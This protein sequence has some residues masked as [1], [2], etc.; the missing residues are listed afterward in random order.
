MG[1]KVSK[2]ENLTLVDVAFQTG[3]SWSEISE[4]EGVGGF[5][6]RVM[7]RKDHY[8]WK[9]AAVTAW[10][11]ARST[12]SAWAGPRWAPAGR[13]INEMA[14][15]TQAPE[16][17]GSTCTAAELSSYAIPIGDLGHATSGIYFLWKA[18]RIVYVG[19]SKLGLARVLQHIAAG[20]KHFD[21]LS[22]VRCPVAQL[23]ACERAYIN[24]FLPELN[25]DSA[26][27]RAKLGKGQSNGGLNA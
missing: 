11:E 8:R 4:L 19:Q 5:P 27:R 26:T 6:R 25:V 24:A 21:G 1:G 17:D 7:I 23:N 10:I 22:F 12:S 2:P 18:D 20:D 14:Y 3:L 16:F 15:M 9:Q 13:L